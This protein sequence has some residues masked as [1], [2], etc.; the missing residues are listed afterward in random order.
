[1]STK[2]CYINIADLFL[3]LSL[4]FV[5]FVLLCWWMNERTNQRTN[6]RS[7]E[8][9]SERTNKQMN[10]RTNE[11]LRTK[12]RTSERTNDLDQSGFHRLSKGVRPYW[13]QIVVDRYKN[14]QWFH[15]F[16]SSDSWM[17]LVSLMGF[18]V[19]R[20]HYK[21]VLTVRSIFAPLSNS[22][23]QLQWQK[24]FIRPRNVRLKLKTWNQKP[25][26]PSD[27]TTENLYVDSSLCRYII[28]SSKKDNLVWVVPCTPVIERT[29]S[30]IS[31]C[32]I[33]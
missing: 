4:F 23:L 11:V 27:Q 5:L 6:E 3:K 22:T 31:L 12:E 29:N 26:D 24:Y 33:N 17:R 10:A 14:K 16:E 1:M 20:S 9:A 15:W 19:S 32:S 21:Y 28:F 2:S 13:S 30:R 8:R 25:K 7:S 18:E